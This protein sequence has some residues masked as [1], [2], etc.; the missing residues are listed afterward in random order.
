[1][2]GSSVIIRPS[3]PLEFRNYTGPVEEDHFSDAIGGLLEIVPHFDQWLDYTGRLRECVAYSNTEGELLGLE[4]NHYG[5]AIWNYLADLKGIDY[6]L[7]RHRI[8]VGPIAIVFG[9]ME[10]ME[11]L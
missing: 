11:A 7:R 4:V 9:D 1:M 10:F 6:R 8:L 2:I 5:S 3:A